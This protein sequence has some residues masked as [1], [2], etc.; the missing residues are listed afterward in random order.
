M[1]VAT[2][3]NTSFGVHEWNKIRSYT[4]TIKFSVSYM[5]LFAI[6]KLLP[7]LRL[8]RQKQTFFLA[9]SRQFGLVQCV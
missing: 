7:A 3:E 4:K 5:I 9:I 6:I 2:S 8:S 1:A